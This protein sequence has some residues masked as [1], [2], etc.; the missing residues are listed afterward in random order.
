M[1]FSPQHVKD[2]SQAGFSHYLPVT[3]SK[4][5]YRLFT[6]PHPNNAR[7]VQAVHGR[8]VRKAQ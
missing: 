8:V 5:P 7:P 2:D 3:I 4:G 1:I 6:Q